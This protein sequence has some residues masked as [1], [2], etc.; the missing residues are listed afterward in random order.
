MHDVGIISRLMKRN[1][2]FIVTFLLQE[3]ML[4]NMRDDVLKSYG[5]EQQMKVGHSGRKENYGKQIVKALIL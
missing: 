5:E 3:V 2:N 4:L 1:F